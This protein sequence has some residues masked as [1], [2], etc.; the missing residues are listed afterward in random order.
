[1]IEENRRSIGETEGRS[2]T[3]FNDHKDGMKELIQKLFTE[4][5][6][7]LWKNVL[8]ELPKQEEKKK[9]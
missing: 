6:V 5:R 4:Y 2:E 1:M 8:N 7:V 3:I 9:I